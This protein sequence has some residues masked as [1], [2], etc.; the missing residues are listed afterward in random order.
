[1][2]AQSVDQAKL[3][4]EVVFMH[5]DFYEQNGGRELELRKKKTLLN[6][7][8]SAFHPNDLNM[9]HAAH[10]RVIAGGKTSPSSVENS[11]HYCGKIVEKMLH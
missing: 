4:R 1:L 10:L 2:D 11:F 9:I 8:C 7:L 6:D 3:S 5:H